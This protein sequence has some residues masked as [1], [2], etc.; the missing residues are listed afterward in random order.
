M[1]HSR[2]TVNPPGPWSLTGEGPA[3]HCP[4]ASSEAGWAVAA[5]SAGRRGTG[6]PQMV[7][8]GGGHGALE[9]TA[10]RRHPLWAATHG[11]LS[12]RPSAATSTGHWCLIPPAEVL[13]LYTLLGPSHS[14]AEE[15]WT[16]PALR[17]Q[18][19]T[20]LKLIDLLNEGWKNLRFMIVKFFATPKHMMS[21]NGMYFYPAHFLLFY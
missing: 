5:L 18:T 10:V 6:H 20:T 17:S 12:C 2:S 7:G 8:G 13:A 16:S 21:W 9:M 1:L 14:A 3:S 15:C 11:G 4:S 19:F